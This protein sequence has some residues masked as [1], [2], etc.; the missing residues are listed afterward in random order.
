M[1]KGI[2]VILSLF[3]L[4]TVSGCGLFSNSELRE[5]KVKVENLEKDVAVLKAA[6]EEKEKE[7]ASL[8][9][10]IDSLNTVIAQKDEALRIAKVPPPPAPPKDVDYSKVRK[11]EVEIF[12]GFDSTDITPAAEKELAKVVEFLQNNKSTLFVQGFADPQGDLDYN[13]WL[14]LQRS[15]SARDAII[16]LIGKGQKP[17]DIV[18]VGR[19]VIKSDGSV[20]NKEK[21]KVVITAVEDCSGRSTPRK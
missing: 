12:F 21:R 7:N 19:G 16:K 13:I 6:L 17:C 11:I 14:S 20:P 9:A 8:R 15:K 2:L 5:L 3:I 18:T 1:K 4:A 10:E